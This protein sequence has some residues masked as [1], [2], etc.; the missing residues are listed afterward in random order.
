MLGPSKTTTGAADPRQRSRTSATARPG[1][2]YEAHLKTPTQDVTGVTIPG[3]PFVVLGHNRDIA[4]GFTN[5]MLDG[6]DFF[7]EKLR[8]GSPGE[9]MSHGEWVKLEERTETIR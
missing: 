3:L 5:V 9:V 7:V 8:P 1:I 6:A 2:W 4:W